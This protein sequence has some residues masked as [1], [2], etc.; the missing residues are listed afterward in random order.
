[1]LKVNA[2][3][4][5]QKQKWTRQVTSEQAKTASVNETLWLSVTIMILFVLAVAAG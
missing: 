1:M 4:N 2:F 5:P 3:F